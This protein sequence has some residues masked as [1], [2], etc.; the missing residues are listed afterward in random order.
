M[1]LSSLGKRY[2]PRI[3]RELRALT[4]F[5]E[6]YASPWAADV[7]E[8]YH[9]MSVGKA[10][11]GLLTLVGYGSVAGR[12]SPDAIRLAAAI[13]LMHAALIIHDDVIDQ[14]S[15][16]RGKPSVV[17]QYAALARRRHDASHVADGMAFLAGDVGILHG[18]RALVAMAAKS[19]AGA[20][21]ADAVLA[22][23]TDTGFGEM[24]DVAL[25]TGLQGVS[26]KSILQMLVGKTARYSCAM[27]L[28]AG[29]HLAG[30]S[31]ALADKL[32][33]IG[34]DLGLIFQLRDDELGLFGTTEQIGKP[35]G[36]DVREG[37][38]TLYSLY[39]RDAASPSERK[40]LARIYGS[41]AATESD[42]QYV[43]E[44]TTRHGVSKKIGRIVAR[45]E[46]R[47]A[48]RIAALRIPA[49]YRALIAEALAYVSG[50]QS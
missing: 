38:Q 20:R 3:A 43:R 4:T 19:R 44:L 14:D 17:A 47:A 33:A 1:T 34:E 5:S 50:R 42:F 45:R 25:G 36:S 35:S 7:E 24:E 48:E 13:E 16:R 27:P 15:I 6:T 49:P 11:R 10:M 12:V 31:Q 39:L 22:Y 37:K 28:V 8:R 21:A 41:S 2:R 46:R 9:G 32:E 29:A 30:G 23:C 18:S 26:E 40:R